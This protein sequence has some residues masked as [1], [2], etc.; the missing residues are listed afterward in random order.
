MK[1]AIR[2]L[3]IGTLVVGSWSCNKGNAPNESVSANADQTQ[4]SEQAEP[5]QA[6]KTKPR[7]T[8]REPERQAPAAESR[9][10]PAAG[11][12]P[13]P[14]PAPAPRARSMETVPSGTALTVTLDDGIS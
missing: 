12:A 6:A 2:L 14:A 4:R 10:A 11:P 1:F 8:N 5:N 13:A 9:R 7:D 3:L